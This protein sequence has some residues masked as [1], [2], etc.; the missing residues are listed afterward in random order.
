MFDCGNTIFAALSRYE[1]D[2]SNPYQGTDHSMS[3]GNGGLMNNR[4]K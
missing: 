4:R 1:R 3:A 2:R